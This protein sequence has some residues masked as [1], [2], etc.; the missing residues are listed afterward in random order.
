MAS[1]DELSRTVVACWNREDWDAYA[2]LAG[3]G[4]AYEEA[5][6]GRRVEDLDAVLAAWRRVREAFPDATADVV[7]VLVRG[8]VTVTGVVWRATHTGPVQTPAGLESPTYMKVHLADVI[9]TTWRDGRMVTERHNL[10]F[11]SVLAPV[12]VATGSAGCCC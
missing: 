11:P 3:P 2:G 8:A 4:F 10:G 1:L 9:T 6:S 5:A 7:D 12:L